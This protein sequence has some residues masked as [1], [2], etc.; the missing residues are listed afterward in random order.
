M[1]DF[2]KSLKD[3]LENRPEPHFEESAWNALDNQLNQLEQQKGRIVVWPW[4]SYVLLALL[5]LSVILNGWLFWQN[6]QVAT[7]PITTNAAMAP[8][9]DTVFQTRFVYQFD[10]VHHTQIIEKQKLVPIGFGS[11]W[12]N[13][14]Q[15][16]MEFW[17]QRFSIQGNKSTD[18]SSVVTISEWL[19]SRAIDTA[20]PLAIHPDLGKPKGGAE[21]NQE[22]GDKLSLMPLQ[23]LG[24]LLDIPLQKENANAY[25]LPIAAFRPTRPP[26][27]SALRPQGLSIGLHGGVA[28][29][30][31]E[32]VED[33][34][35]HY[36]GINLALQFPGHV[37]LWGELGFQNINYKVYEMDEA[38]GVP[39]KE[40]PVGGFTFYNALVL[41][42]RLYYAGG[43]K[44]RF[45][46]LGSRWRPVVEMGYSSLSFLP[47]EIYYEFQD[48]NIDNDIRLENHIDRKDGPTHYLI[49]RAGYEMV[50]NKRWQWQ[51]M[52]EFRYSLSEN[53]FTNP[54]L[55]GL[56]A[57]LSYQF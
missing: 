13:R 2:Y 19:Q 14:L 20:Y 28:Y 54:H 47:Y 5:P 39:V 23:K 26:F 46:H 49:T 18:V 27:L 30:F 33:E 24:F 52:G 21:T 10:T 1:D 40:A 7:T 29:P 31:L 9:V 36:R 48:P 44:Y 45:L 53:T 50:L 56:K 4:W 38:L 3:N 55:L 51:I 57:G 16:D 41:Q 12:K 32:R 6:Q 35:A 22:K 43:L 25:D 11:S 8:S 15:G 34:A 37:E 17:T 42:S